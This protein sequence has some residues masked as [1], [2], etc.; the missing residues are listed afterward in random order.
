MLFDSVNG[1]TKAYDIC[2]DFPVKEKLL[3]ESASSLEW[4]KETNK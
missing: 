2:I 1:I 3:Y 4:G